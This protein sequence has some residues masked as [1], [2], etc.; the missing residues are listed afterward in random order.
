MTFGV[1]YQFVNAPIPYPE[2]WKNLP[3][4]AGSRLCSRMPRND[5]LSYVKMWEKTGGRIGG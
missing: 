5:Y 3:C 2:D 4:I 1:A